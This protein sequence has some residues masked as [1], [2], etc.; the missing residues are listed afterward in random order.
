MNITKMTV[1]LALTCAFTA[2]HAEVWQGVKEDA[3]KAWDATKDNAGKVADDVKKA[4]QEG[5][6]TSVDQ[7]SEDAKKQGLK[8]VKPEV[9]A[10]GIPK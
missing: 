5:K 9:D 7:L 4:Y 2:V 10:A 8:P 3:A 6:N 1:V